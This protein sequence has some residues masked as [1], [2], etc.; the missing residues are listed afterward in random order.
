MNDPQTQPMTRSDG[1]PAFPIITPERNGQP[2]GTF[3]WAR[4]L[5]IRD[6][7]AG[8]AISALLADR[9]VDGTFERFAESAYLTADA[10][11]LERE[12]RKA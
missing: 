8:M 2:L 7:F 5:S 6:W 4:G 9:S 10:M 3:I 11:L 1:G 12:K